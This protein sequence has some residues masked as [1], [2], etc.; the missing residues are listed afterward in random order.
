L[1]IRR[2]EELP[3]YER[4]GDDESRA[5]AIG[6]I[7]DSLRARGELDEALRVRREEQLPL[8]ERLGDLGARATTLGSIADIL[9]EKG[10]LV[11]ARA[12]QEERLAM[13]RRLFDNAE[14]APGKWK[15]ALPQSD[16]A[17]VAPAL[18]KL[19]QLDLAEGKLDDAVP[20][21]IEA[22][23]IEMSLGRVEAIS[24]I[25]M[26]LARVLA[27]RAKTARAGD[28]LRRIAETLRELGADQEAQE[29]EHLLHELSTDPLAPSAAVT[30]EGST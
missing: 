25:G 29:A 24:A 17:G 13:F 12:L 19:A 18:W 22:H 7:A 10:D 26:E 8:Y 2:E 21:L 14:N 15:V 27:A 28:L 23:D 4:L 1:R 3:I 30:R 16:V 5:V 9:T 20:R 6:Q 11:A